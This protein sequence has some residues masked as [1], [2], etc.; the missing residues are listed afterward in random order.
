[1]AKYEISLQ[2]NFNEFLRYCEQ[3][4]MTGSLSASLEDG[5]DFQIGEV[6]IAVRVFERYSFTGSNR[7]SLN[8]TLVGRNNDITLSAITAGGS[9][10]TLFK[11]NTIGEHSFLNQF[12]SLVEQY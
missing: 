3:S 2:A 11:L 7:L 4:I 8:L 10:A 6:R 9:Q 5:S 1:M 12:I